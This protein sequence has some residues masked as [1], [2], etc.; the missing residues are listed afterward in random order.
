MEAVF[1]FIIKN[2]RYP[3]LEQENGVQ[4]KVH[5]TFMVDKEMVH[6]GCLRR[7]VSG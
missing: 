4:G 1:A 3:D 6:S 7:G 5:V 2:V